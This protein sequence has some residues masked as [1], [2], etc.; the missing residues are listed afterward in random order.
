MIHPVSECEKDQ[1]HITLCLYK[2]YLI[3]FLD[4]PPKGITELNVYK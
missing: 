3:Q 4:Q 2:A 1:T